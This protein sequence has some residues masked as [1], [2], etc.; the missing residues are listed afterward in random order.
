MGPGIKF[1]AHLV[2]PDGRLVG[3]KKKKVVEQT[4][5]SGMKIVEIPKFKVVDE[6]N[7]LL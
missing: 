2:G 5:P 1:P 3:P 4:S 7:E 6:I